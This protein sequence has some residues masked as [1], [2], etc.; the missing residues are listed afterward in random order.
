MYNPT[1]NVA[2]GSDAVFEKA[3]FDPR[4]DALRKDLGTRNI[5]LLLVTKPENIFYL[6]G[7][8]TVGYYTLQCLG[9]P[10]RG[11]PFLLLWELE[12]PQAK[13]NTF[14][15][16][17]GM[18][19]G[20]G[21]QIES[22]VE[23]IKARGWKGKRIAIERTSW[24]L[25]IDMYEK[26]DAA[27]GP[28]IDGSGIVEPLRR[29]KSPVE[30]ECIEKAA[31]AV[32]AAT[33]AA[34][35]LI[36]AGVS[37]NEIAAAVHAAMFEAGSE[38]VAMGPF[39]CSGPRSGLRHA[40]WR[41]R[42]LKPGETFTIEIAAAYNRYHSAI[43]RTGCVPP[44]PDKVRRFRDV[45]L[46]GLAA[47]LAKMRPGNTCADVHNAVQATIDKSGH[48]DLFRKR[49]G[50]SLGI[51]FAPGWG[52]GEVIDLAPENETVLAPGMVF[53]IPVTLCQFG[54]FTVGASETAVVT[55]SGNR[56]LNSI[57]R[58]LF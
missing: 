42:I 10:A 33:R 43:F 35:P 14:V 1:K 48:A 15:K 23:M 50:Y 49:S 22:V 54:E 31:R 9:V 44:V 39:L 57:D 32:E 12:G 51:A 41:R 11:E 16:D 27:L 24:F 25:P 21:G 47:G 17:I 29:V 6:S 37:E 28:F 36:R 58:A 45:C 5:D 8:Q 52:E 40:T 19:Y 46:E 20:L 18:Y 2:S 13:A 55:A 56:V 30:L 26:L 4:L 38:W 53:H 7:Q 34:I 3:E